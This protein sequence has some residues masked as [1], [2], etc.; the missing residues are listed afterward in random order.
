MALF[1]F[2][3]NIL[4]NKKIDVYN[5]GN[6]YRDFTYVDDTV[7]RVFKIFKKGPK[8]KKSDYK[9][10]LYPD[11]SN[12]PFTIFN[13]GNNRKTKLKTFIKILE[14]KLK[15]K[16][17]INYKEIQKGDVKSTVT[18]NRKLSNFIKINKIT[19]HEIGIQNFIEW[20]LSFFNSAK[21]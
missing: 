3:K 18:S 7:D 5:Y 13:V 9:N 8:F 2:T 10:N 16:A 14:K 1:K 12:S 6:M 11:E 19:N 21:M 20:Y 15:K 17:L 4:K